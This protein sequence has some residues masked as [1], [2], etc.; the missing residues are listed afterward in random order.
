MFSSNKNSTFSPCMKCESHST[1]RTTVITQWHPTVH[2]L[3]QPSP[4][5][6]TTADG[7]RD[8]L[9]NFKTEAKLLFRGVR[10]ISLF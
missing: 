3:T 7:S 6:F 2:E 10:M 8:R 5:F 9:L 1:D 4:T